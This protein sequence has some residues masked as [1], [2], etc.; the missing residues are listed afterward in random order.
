MIG[1]RDVVVIRNTL[2]HTEA[3]LEGLRKLVGRRLHRCA[4]E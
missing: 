4:I 1:V 2:D 3:L